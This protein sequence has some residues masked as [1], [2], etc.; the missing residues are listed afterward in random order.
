MRFDFDHE[1]GAYKVVEGWP[2]AGHID[3]K[4]ATPKLS[5]PRGLIYV[6]QR[7]DEPVNGHHDWMLTAI[8]FRTGWRVFRIKGYF[9]K[10]EFDDNVTRIVQ[11]AALGKG[12]YDRI[13]LRNELLLA[14][15]GSSVFFD[16]GRVSPQR[17]PTSEGSSKAPGR[18]R[19]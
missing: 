10:G 7:D 3:A 1:V 2:A 4:T 8:D 13:V 16:H 11:R 9:N 12:T 6:Y 15:V 5:T 17:S 14:A 19:S 18:R